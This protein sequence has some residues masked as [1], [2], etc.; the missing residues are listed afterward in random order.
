MNRPAKPL[1]ILVADDVKDIRE[2]I[3]QWLQPAGHKIQVVASGREASALLAKETFDVLITDVM[4]PDGDAIGLIKDAKK[5]QPNLNIL[6]I[7]G[8]SRYLDAKECVKMAQ[9]LGAHATLQKPFT[10]EQLV[11][12]MGQAA[13]VA[14]AMRKAQAQGP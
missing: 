13:A 5:V 3:T 10:R 14:A 4:M 12:G 9:A 11:T 1:S 7:S 6:A 2:L 8:G